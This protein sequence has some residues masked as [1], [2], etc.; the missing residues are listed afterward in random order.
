MAKRKRG[1]LALDILVAGVAM[2]ALT[3]FVR[4]R[5][6]PWILERYVLDPGELVDEVPALLDARTG[7]GVSP[8]EGRGSLLLV[9]RSTCPVCEDAVPAWNRL[10][11]GDE[12]E[13]TAVGLEDAVPAAAY[14]DR[15]MPG[16]PVAVPADLDRFARRFRITVVP[17]TLLIDREGR[18]AAR[19]AGPLEAS[20]VSEIR[21]L[22]APRNT[23]SN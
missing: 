20:V 23:D 12:W 18:L 11:A 5:L 1:Q 21:R 9:F 6:V 8:P 3:L 4:E 19:H 2:L 17:T 10:A 7:A 14:V 13:V 16:L 15:H 22:A